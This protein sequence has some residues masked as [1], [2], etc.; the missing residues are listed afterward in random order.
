M[1]WFF[2]LIVASL[3]WNQISSVFGLIEKEDDDPECDEDELEEEEEDDL[4]IEENLHTTP[5]VTRVS[6]ADLRNQFVHRP[7]VIKRRE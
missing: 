4:K 1:E 2:L 7:T 6:K 5:T 3:F